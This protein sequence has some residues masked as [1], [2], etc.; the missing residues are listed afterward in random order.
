M[1]QRVPDWLQSAFASDQD[2][3]V[4]TLIVRQLFALGLGCIVG[5]TYR[6]AQAKEGIAQPRQ[7][8]EMHATLV[9]LT[10]LISM[11][12][13]VI[14]DNIAR[15][16]SI[17]GAL[18]I[19]RFR[20]VVEDTRDTAFVIFAVAVGMAA[21]AGHIVLPLVTIPIIA[22][23]A[24][25]FRPSAASTGGARTRADSTI[26]FRLTVRSGS[27]FD[28]MQR[29]RGVGMQFGSSMRLGGVESARQGS[30]VEHRFAI[31]LPTE[32]AATSLMAELNRIEGVQG[33]ELER[34]GDRR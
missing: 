22:I 18:S 27:G 33:V 1:E 29:I 19:V 20:T 30:A 5:L 6:L 10:V 9:L 15:A 34:D 3:S 7:R 16:F 21:G 32:D 31:D 24:M 14:G 28:V 25:L 13:A 4:T 26:A 12:T 17:V 2:V 8:A 23:A 11:M